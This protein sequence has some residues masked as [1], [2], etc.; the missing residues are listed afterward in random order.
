MPDSGVTDAA[1]IER[2]GSEDRSEQRLAC[3]RIAERL[4]ER[5]EL[6][7][8]LLGALHEG[9]RLARFAAAFVLFRTERPGLRLLPALLDA[10]EVPDGDIRWQATHMLAVL[11]RMHGEVLPV[12]LHEAREAS[13]PVRRRMALYALRELAP[14]RPETAEACLAALDD[15]VREVRRAA[16]TCFGKLAGAERPALER[17]LAI[18]SGDPD[19]AMR[20]LAAVALPNLVS[21]HADAL[22]AVRAA[23]LELGRSE[24]GALARAAVAAGARL[25]SLA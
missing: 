10:L 18:A 11:G 17:V 19:P 13:H 21:A 15:G 12:V 25:E 2:L 4:A 6:R 23:I 1:L 7:A 22:P 5:P 3:D 20:A 9:T 24:D 14:E 8:A 16:L